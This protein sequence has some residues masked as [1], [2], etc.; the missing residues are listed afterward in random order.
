MA[1]G[2]EWQLELER[3]VDPR[4]AT[5]ASSAAA[6]SEAFNYAAAIAAS[7]AQASA[8]S[9]AE[10]FPSLP[11]SESGQRGGPQNGSW[12]KS[13]VK[14]PP[15]VAKSKRG[16]PQEHASI[17]LVESFNNDLSLRDGPSA[18]PPPPAS[19]YPPLPSGPSWSST[20]V[21]STSVRSERDYPPLPGSSASFAVA[22]GGVSS[23]AATRASAPAA[24]SSVHDYPTLPSSGG[25]KK[26]RLVQ[27]F[28]A[29]KVSDE[30]ASQFKDIRSSLMSRG[31]GKGPSLSA[32]GSW[33]SSQ[34]NNNSTSISM[35]RSGPSED[36]YPALARVVPNS[37]IAHSSA[38][39]GSN[40]TSNDK[41]ASQPSKQALKQAAKKKQ[42]E[43]LRNL[44]FLK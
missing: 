2:G 31:A 20:A 12:G 25:G 11:P 23:S 9:R 8:S 1:N 41:E 33:T 34:G 35:Q 14:Q 5:S 4:E 10:D 7:R 24:I 21:S 28:E 38:S 29:G 17:R 13:L 15:K 22:R 6:S 30:S 37:G 36:D 42:R 40:N 16:Q 43:E 3:I 32:Y 39:S 19:D 26:G 27:K 18:P 44:A